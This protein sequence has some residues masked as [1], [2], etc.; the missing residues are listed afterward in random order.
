MF[1]SVTLGFVVIAALSL[2][3]GFML[4][5]HVWEHRRFVR[6]GFGIDLSS[7]FI[8]KVG[9]IVPCK[10]VDLKLKENLRC[11]FDQTFA[12]YEIYFVVEQVQDPAW[13]VIRKLIDSEKH[14]AANLVVAGQSSERGQKIHNLLCGYKALSP[15]IETIVFADC[16]V[17]PDRDWISRLTAP[18]HLVQ[19]HAVSSYRWFL[20]LKGTFVNFLLSS[21]NAAA[22]GLTGSR[23]DAIIWGGSWAITRR[24]FDGAEIPRLWQKLISD[25]LCATR[26]FNQLR[27]NIHFEPRCIVK[28]PID[29]SFSGMWEFLRRQ[30]FMGR[31]YLPGRW[32]AGLAYTS[33]NMLAFWG[34]LLG[35]ISLAIGGHQWAGVTGVAVAALLWI[36]GAIRAHWRHGAAIFY[37]RGEYEQQQRA[38][39]FDLCSY[40]L[41]LT[42]LW[43]ALLS[44]SVARCIR[45]RGILYHLDKSGT[46]LRVQRDELAANGPTPGLITS[47]ENQS[48]QTSV[49]SK[50]P[51]LKL[52]VSDAEE[53]VGDI[54]MTPHKQR[55][56]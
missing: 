56:A 12:N 32:L 11:L 30:C 39:W 16:D 13:R 27:L 5:C 28:T 17:A 44:V 26:R 3:A 1:I 54:T 46:V 34:G 50:F 20:P 55:A 47:S 25:D 14:V 37:M 9:V 7:R 41:T 45:W 22:M 24:V 42:I 33:L 10:D 2:L 40:P 35:G 21:I 19:V 23:R 51:R 8:G 38:R 48:A 52:H 36:L 4:T 53:A 49:E 29:Y 6:G 15:D 43:C 18:L 31:R